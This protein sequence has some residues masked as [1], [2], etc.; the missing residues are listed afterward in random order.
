MPPLES[1]VR[2]DPDVPGGTP[3]FAGTRVPVKNLLD[4]LAA[5][6]W[7]RAV[8]GREGATAW[9]AAPVTPPPLP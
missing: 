7:R 5:D 1:V 2:R 9:Y 8:R 4:Y 6:G 3:V